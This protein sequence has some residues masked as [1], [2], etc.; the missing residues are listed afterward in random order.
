MQVSPLSGQGMGP[1]PGDYGQAFAFCKILYPLACAPCCQ[2]TCPPL[3][4][5]V[6]GVQPT[7]L[8]SSG[9]DT[10]GIAAPCA[11]RFLLYPG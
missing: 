11:L 2:G 4:A 7:G 3:F 10:W 8:P 5:N 1:Y 6:Q 9:C